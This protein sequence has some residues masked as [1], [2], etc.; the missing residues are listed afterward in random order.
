M[1]PNL[2]ERQ[3]Q[4]VALLKAEGEVKIAALSKQFQVTEM[5]IRRDLEK[6]EQLTLLYRT[7]GGA[8]SSTSVDMPL[9]ERTSVRTDEKAAIGRAAAQLIRPGE[10]VFLDAG[11]TTLQIARRI[12]KGADI[13]VVTNALNV[14]AE[15]NGRQVQTLVIGG[16]LREATSS[17]VGP[18]AE[19]IMQKMA[20]DR[21]FLGASGFTLEH[22]FNN[23]NVY[24]AELKRIAM[25]KGAEVNMV[26]DHTKFGYQSLA[27]FATL[28]QVNRIITN[29]APPDEIVA[30]C[31]EAGVDLLIAE[32]DD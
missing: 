9:G 12:P 31:R 10:A 24:E 11:T 27:S 17:L 26:L 32:S 22:G 13:T 15:L 1:K 19:E 14:A 21:V 25:T 8:I 18:F 6:L 28:R 3:E 4:I 20:Y 30:A 5:T 16:V 23:S 29:A 7:L 2:N